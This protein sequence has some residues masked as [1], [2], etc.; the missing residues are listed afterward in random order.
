MARE[1]REGGGR[2]VELN[3]TTIAPPERQAD[4]PPAN[5]INKYVFKRGHQVLESLNRRLLIAE[6]GFEALLSIASPSKKGLI[7]LKSQVNGTNV[8]ML[9]D[10]GA[11]NFFMTANSFMRTFSKVILKEKPRLFALLAFLVCLMNFGMS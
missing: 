8:S 3:S 1:C 9:I 11:S 7:Y 2:K 4:W 10:T 6:G 5:S